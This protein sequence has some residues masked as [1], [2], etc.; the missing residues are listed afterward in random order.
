MSG[1][2]PFI[3]I[4]ALDQIREGFARGDAQLVLTRDLST[5]L[6][7]NGAGASLF[8]H[9]R[10]ED[11]IGGALDLPVATR[12]QITAST[13]ETDIA[14]RIVAV[15]LGGGMRA[16][17]TR[18][19][20]SNI[21]LPDGI[22]ALLMSVD[23]QDVKPGDI[24]SGLADDTTHVALIDAQ[25]RILAASSRFA[26]LDISAST[27]EDLIV[28]AKMRMITQSSGVFVRESIQFRVRWRVSQ[29][30]LLCTCSALSAKQHRRL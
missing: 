23:R 26:A 15:R 9:D 13:D 20:I 24:I 22:E 28:E 3:D 27:L 5:V 30:T 19:K 4:A 14:P 10:I 12:R 16:E 1:S 18:L 25:A 8:G 17:L 2:Y 21:V 29:T 7:A 11:L 6:W